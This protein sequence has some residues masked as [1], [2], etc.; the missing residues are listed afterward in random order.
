MIKSIDDFGFDESDFL[1]VEKLLKRP[2]SGPFKVTVRNRTTK[3]IVVIA[4]YPI[5]NSG[6]PMPTLFWL[7]GKKESKLVSRI[8]AEF[9][10]K[11]VERL[12]NET[13]IDEIH[14]R[15]SAMRH[16][17]LPK[18]YAG[19]M[20]QGGVGGTGRGLK[21]L[22]AHLANFLATRQDAVGS[23][24]AGTCKLNIDEYESEL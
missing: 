20:P 5:L 8:E 12:F 6:V 23:W 13:E 11:F 19:L 16:E 15:Y 18:N 22:H 17:L 1:E 7:L 21:C 14:K 24:V 9:G 10:L 3:G 4:N 2:P